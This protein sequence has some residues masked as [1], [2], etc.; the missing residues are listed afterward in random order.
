LNLYGAY[1][2][3][4][5]FLVT[6]LFTTINAELFTTYFDKTDIISSEVEYKDGTR[7]DVE[8]GIKHGLE[9]VY[10]DNGKIAFTVNNIEGQRDGDLNW[11]DQQ[12]NHLEVMPYVMGKRHG[13]NKIYY[14]N[15]KL[16]SEVNYVND[17]KEGTEKLYFD[18]GLLAQESQY[19][20]DKKEGLEKEYNN[21]GT[22]L[23]TV[24][25]KNNY[26]EG[27]KKFFDSKGNVIKTELYTKDRQE[28]MI[29]KVKNMEN[30]HIIKGFESI[31]FNP[32][33]QTLK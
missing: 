7:S 6:L 9:K 21:D 17:K 3:K 12:G 14:A 25:Y 10:H 33:N 24:N 5:F 22:L 19:K 8:E 28:G 2:S 16:R 29:Q 26:K 13:T 30:N 4:H 18:T 31:D 27:E 23:S 15:G 32:Q 20:N 1:M 11:Y